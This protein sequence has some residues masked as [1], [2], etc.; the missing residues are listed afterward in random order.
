MT[1]ADPNTG[2]HYSGSLGGN[3]VTTSRPAPFTR[4]LSWLLIDLKEGVLLP[5]DIS[6]MLSQEAKLGLAQEYETFLSSS[7]PKDIAD[8]IYGRMSYHI[9]YERWG[10]IFKMFRKWLHWTYSFPY[11]Q[12]S[13]MVIELLK[14]RMERLPHDLLV[15]ECRRN[16]SLLPELVDLSLAAAVA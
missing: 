10:I 8:A 4:L 14:D 13:F 7:N 16:L 2:T 9:S 12:R 1:I 5:S 3:S 15:E 11:T 6:A